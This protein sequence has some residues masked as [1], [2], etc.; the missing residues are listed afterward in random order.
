MP[1]ESLA[2]KTKRRLLGVLFIALVASLITLS[3]AIYNKA[4]TPTVDVTL[5]AD[6][7][8]NQLLLDS[9]V[10][11]RGII[12]GSVK[13]VTAKGDPSDPDKTIAVVKLALDPD[14]VKDIP[15]NVS[16]Q[17][18][19]KTLFGEQYVSLTLPTA[20]AGKV[21]G[22][23]HIR[24]GDVIPQDRSQGALEAQDVLGDLL[25]LLTAVQPAEL[26]STLTALA[27][28]LNGRGA[29][30]GRTL[31]NLDKYLKIINPHTQDLVNDLQKLGKVA[32]EYNGVAPD[33]FATL[34]NLQTSVRTVVQK[35]QNLDNLLT[36]GTSTSNVVAGFLT[37]NR[38]RLINV[39]GQSAKVF[40]LLNKYSPE[41]TCLLSG[42]NKLADGV[43]D[44][45]YDN[46]I[47][48]EI[49]V[50]GGYNTTKYVPGDT[51]SLVTGYGP[52]C[53]GLP[54]TPTPT[55]DGKFQ[56]PA[57]Y[58]CLNDG[59]ALTD[60]TTSGCGAKQTAAKVTNPSIGS[61]AESAMVNTLVAASLHTTPNKVPGGTT[62]LAAPLLRGHEVV[63]K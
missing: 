12:V 27:T 46:Q 38:Q 25:P 48:L 13:S 4:F 55:V 10:K 44:A 20:S 31:V 7:T 1:A 28:A 24:S 58:Q 33:I 26:N 50:D 42:I 14:R 52:N 63:V 53:F 54:G 11:E 45:I 34:Q 40:S 62:L 21:A 9:D 16:A 19:P 6:H 36:T 51:P 23:R 30:L 35:Q 61:A 5:Q 37:D 49:T 2:T 47:H 41:F 8:G 57:K 22:V 60:P 3:I 15:S 29:E 59:A 17:I 32:L 18:L 43:G 56:I 39:T